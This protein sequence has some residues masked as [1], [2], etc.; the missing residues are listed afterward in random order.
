L[1]CDVAS[2]QGVADGGHVVKSGRPRLCRSPRAVDDVCV[3]VAPSRLCGWL[4]P[5]IWSPS[6]LVARRMSAQSLGACA[7]QLSLTASAYMGG[8]PTGCSAICPPRSQ[9]L[10]GTYPS[11]C[12]FFQFIEDLVAG[13][14]RDRW[15]NV[16]YLMDEFQC[17]RRAR[18][19]AGADLLPRTREGRL[20][21]CVLSRAARLRSVDSA[22]GC[23]ASVPLRDPRS[24]AYR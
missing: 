9:M 12:W 5:P 16:Q 14:V 10:P 4:E 3:I 1:T 11:S 6:G 21:G 17:P 22:P 24:R 18:S 20:R 8:W 2:T 7:E 15:A 23:L 19:I 13:R